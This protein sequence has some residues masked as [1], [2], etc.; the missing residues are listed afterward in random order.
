MWLIAQ[1]D[2]GSVVSIVA[3]LAIGILAVVGLWKVFAKAGKPGWAAIV[4]IYNFIVLLEIVGRPAWWTVLLL[5]PC[6]NVFAGLIVSLDLAKAFNKGT[7][8]AIGLW[9]IGFIFL[10][11]LGFSS[12]QYV[13]PA[14]AEH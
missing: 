11:V 5:L 3:Y 13:G 2:G 8:F 10:P 12:A 1:N 4:P 7:G 9:L 6:I 14:A